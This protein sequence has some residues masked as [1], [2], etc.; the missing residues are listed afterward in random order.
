MNILAGGIKIRLN[1]IHE[2]EFKNL[3]N[4]EI[5]EEG[6]FILNSS[7]E[8]PSFK[9]MKEAFKTTYYTLYDTEKGVF[10]LQRYDDNIV[11]GIL[12]EDKTITM[13]L[14]NDSFQSEYLMSQYAFVYWIRNYTKGIFIHS[15]S[16]MVNDKG[17]LI[18]AKSGTGKSTHRR[19]WEK[20]GAICL[21]DDKNV[22]ALENDKLYILPNP[23]SGKHFCDNNFKAELKAVVFIYQSKE[24]VYEELPKDKALA[25]LLNQIQLPSNAFKDSWNLIVDKLLDLKLA[26]YGCNMEDSA[27][28][29]LEANIGGCLK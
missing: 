24:N 4:Y 13:Y 8:K 28:F 11:G 7:L 16:I 25:L 5:Q 3:A 1:L 10:Q 19:L 2:A 15:S 26:R 20:F 22:I 27:Y 12:Y 17:F 23:W 6:E 29:T 9:E 14:Y 18:C 21:N